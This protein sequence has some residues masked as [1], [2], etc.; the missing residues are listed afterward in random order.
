MNKLD[1]VMKNINQ[2]LAS[3]VISALLYC[4]PI[5]VLGQENND[6]SPWISFGEMVE[7]NQNQ[8]KKI[9]LF[10]EADW[11]SVC[12]RMKREVFP[13]ST[14]QTLLSTEFYPIRIDIESEETVQFS[15]AE[16]TMEELSKQFGI[17]GTPTIIFLEHD[18]SVIGNS[19]GYSDKENF[20]ALLKFI[21]DEEYHQKSLDEYMQDL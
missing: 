17:R 2:I 15:D 3:I 12:K 19:V 14:I 1:F 21:R 4:N 8:P 10:M 5:D 18:F 11:C 20:T 7:L 9:M 16:V 13:D 6:S